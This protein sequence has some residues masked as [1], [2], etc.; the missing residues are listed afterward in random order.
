MNKNPVSNSD[1]LDESITA[2]DLI[3][4]NP[5]I[6]MD[7]IP[8]KIEVIN[9]NAMSQIEPNKPKI[10]LDDYFDS[11]IDS[12]IDAEMIVTDEINVKKS[13]YNFMIDSINHHKKF[14]DCIELSQYIE[15]NSIKTDCFYVFKL[16]KGKD[17]IQFHMRKISDIVSA[18]YKYHTIRLL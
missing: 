9:P 12:Y 1:K 8:K 14:R 2:F 15:A 5:L 11:V 7:K 3:S 13:D 10:D 18:V 16:V 17:T 4:A 6:I